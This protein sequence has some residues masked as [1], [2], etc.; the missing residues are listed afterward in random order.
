MLKL[1]KKENS[2]QLVDRLQTK[3]I[4]MLKSKTK[5]QLIPHQDPSSLKQKQ[6]TVVE[7]P[8][9]ETAENSRVRRNPFLKKVQS[10]DRKPVRKISRKEVLP[11]L[12]Q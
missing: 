8:E 12:P 4:N 9:E 1:E 10:V 2:T 3:I 7:L 6:H 5:D 11:L